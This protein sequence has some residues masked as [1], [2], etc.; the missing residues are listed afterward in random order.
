[1]S[2]YS[3]NPATLEPDYFVK[4]SLQYVTAGGKTYG[5]LR[6]AIM[7]RLTAT[8]WFL[9]L[10]TSNRTTCVCVCV[11]VSIQGWLIHSIPKKILYSDTLLY[12]FQNFVRKE[13]A[14]AKIKS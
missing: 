8:I 4:R 13:V 1:M 9:Q 12:G 6:H 2:A 7:V 10:E 14:K 3:K 5:S 11:H